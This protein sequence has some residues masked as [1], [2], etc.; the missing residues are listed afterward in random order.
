MHK[1]C[2]WRVIIY[3]LYGTDLVRRMCLATTA[4]SIPDSDERGR[5][6]ARHTTHTHT[7]RLGGTD[8]HPR[9]QVKGRG[10]LS[11]RLPARSH[12][13]GRNVGTLPLVSKVPP[14]PPTPHPCTP[15]RCQI[16]KYLSEG[17]IVVDSGDHSDD[18]H[19]NCTARA[20]LCV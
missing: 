3:L 2:S 17:Y 5:E 4:S 7:H 18:V 16:L 6:G 8:L 12:Y 1:P 13:R 20:Q 14:R 11:L 19:P 15:G 10:L 9:V